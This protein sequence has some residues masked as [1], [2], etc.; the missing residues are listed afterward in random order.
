MKQ[1]YTLALGLLLMG[2][3]ANAETI[4]V[5]AADGLQA[6]IDA[7]AEGDVIELTVDQTVTKRVGLTD[8]TLTVKGATDGIRI[9]RGEKYTSNAVILVNGKSV[10]TFSNLIFDGNNVSTPKHFFEAAGNGNVTLDGVKLT[11][12]ISTENELVK[13]IQSSRLTLNDFSITECTYPAGKA[14]VIAGNDNMTVGG[15]TTCS[16][17]VER[18]RINAS[19]GFSGMISM[20]VKTFS[21]RDIVNGGKVENF[22]LMN[23]EPYYSLVQNGNNVQLAYNKPVVTN[24]ATGVTYTDFMAAYNALAP[25]E[26][27]NNVVLEV[28]EN[29]S[30]TDRL[31]NP[32][33]TVFTVRGGEG[34]ITLT[35]TFRDKLLVSNG[36]SMYFQNVTID[37][38]N[39]ANNKYEFEANQNNCTLDLVDVVIANSAS[40]QGIFTVKDDNRVLSLTNVQ[41]TGFEGAIGVHLNGKLELAG[42][43]V[44][45]A[46][47]IANAK[48]EIKVVDGLTN[49]E[50][51]K[52]VFAD[53]IAPAQGM[54]LVKNC[55]DPSKFTVDLGENPNG[56]KLV[57][58]GEDLALDTESGVNDLTVDDNAPAEYYNLQGVRVLNPENGLYI[59]RQG[60]KAVKVMVK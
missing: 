59:R 57:V 29:A 16:I 33:N 28:T 41:V 20:L 54:V 14:S 8:K 40:T 27:V 55:T 38:N 32:N 11:N 42:N 30:I 15:N 37:C 9:I 52:I 17:Y 46:I 6:A 5:T 21:Q 22:E 12:A 19:E 49:A 2:G 23:S 4:Q 45:P 31:Q 60:N 53:N 34:N 50:P 25:V 3:A 44:I 36:R 58:K 24:T 56:L 35:R 47:R 7:A 1:I 39:Q 51:I 48:A 26:G 43:I 13:G 10:V 18:D